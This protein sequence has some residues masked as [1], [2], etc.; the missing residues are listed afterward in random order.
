MDGTL[1]EMVESNDIGDSLLRPTLEWLLELVR[2]SRQSDPNMPY[3]SR[4]RQF[5]GRRRLS[6]ADL[7]AV[8]RLV[9]REEP[10]LRWVAERVPEEADDVTKLWIS[11]PANWEAE[12]ALIASDR[13]RQRLEEREN[14]AASREAKRRQAA[15]SRA[16]TAESAREAAERRAGELETDLDAERAARRSLESEVDTLRLALGEAKTQLRHEKDRHEATQRRLDEALQGQDD[17]RSDTERAEDIRT[18]ALRE[19]A[20]ALNELDSVR[21]IIEQARRLADRISELAPTE[22]ETARQ[23]VALPGRLTGDRIGAARYLLEVRALVIIDGYNVSKKWHPGASLIDQRD[24]L[25]SAVDVLVARHGTD[26]VVVFDGDDVVGSHT[27]RR[28][29]VRVVWS[30][31]GVTADDVIRAEVRRLPASRQVVVVT[32]DREIIND[33]RSEGANHIS[34]SAFIGLLEG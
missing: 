22:P 31:R 21:D 6:T 32:D 33:V 17:A 12:L 29:P 2:E 34:S 28:S 7:R 27:L 9:E 25:I 1:N 30:P 23:P 19:R 8:R 15:E 24:M 3:P 18:A 5:L 16:A 20:A 11:R 4:L 14:Q 13:G 26:I 10:F